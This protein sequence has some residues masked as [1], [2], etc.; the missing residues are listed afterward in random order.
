MQSVCQKK[1]L[2]ELKLETTDSWEIV[3]KPNDTS[4]HWADR[5]TFACITQSPVLC[6]GSIFAFKDSTT[7]QGFI[8][9]HNGF[10]FSGHRY[11]GNRPQRAWMYHDTS[12][13]L[14]KLCSFPRF[15]SGLLKDYADNYDFA[16]ASPFMPFAD[17]C[18][19]HLNL[20]E[21]KKENVKPGQIVFGTNPK[22]LVAVILGY[23]AEQN[24]ILTLFPSR[25][26]PERD[27][28]RNILP[29]PHN[30][31]EGIGLR[32]YPFS[33]DD[34]ILFDFSPPNPNARA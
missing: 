9:P 24:T 34:L 14:E 13:W 15:Y 18:R 33:L 27:D 11:I 19:T 22:G 2:A 7:A 30:V 17:F 23:N 20:V 31:S 25:G 8:I 1:P 4:T 3:E 16:P 12:S 21:T 6:D 5:V 32:N 10:N 26:D 28:A 29:T